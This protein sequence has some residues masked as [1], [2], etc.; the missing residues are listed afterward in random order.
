MLSPGWKFI[1]FCSELIPGA[2]EIWALPAGY[3]DWRQVCVVAPGPEFMPGPLSPESAHFTLPT[4]KRF[5]NFG[6]DHRS[7]I[8]YIFYI[9]YLSADMQLIPD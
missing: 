6:D 9:S 2:G 7:D 3:Q 4:L 1:V 8:K 5:P